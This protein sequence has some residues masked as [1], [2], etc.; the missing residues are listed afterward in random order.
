M[1]KKTALVYGGAA[2]L[3]V[4]FG[5][6]TLARTLEFPG[7]EQYLTYATVVALLTEF[8]V[9]CW[10]A[11]AIYNEPDSGPI[12]SGGGANIDLSPVKEVT[13]ALDGYT[14]RLENIETSL[15]KHNE[16]VE[17]LNSKIES[18]VDDQLD[19]KVKNILA[20]MVGKKV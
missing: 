2:A 11:L 16:Q 17:S 6:R 10:Y 12:A 13:K 20:D 8:A 5:F 7:V 3:I 14:A 15:N 4:I 1:N 18:I 9:L 19:E